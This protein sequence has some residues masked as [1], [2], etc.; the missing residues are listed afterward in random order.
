MYQPKRLPQAQ[1]S[2]LRRTTSFRPKWEGTPPCDCKLMGVPDCKCDD[3]LSSAQE[4][5][6]LRARIAELEQEV[7]R[8][9][10]CLTDI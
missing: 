5:A 2:D 7:Q 4:L 3:E 10:K 1:G 8:L 6:A 9:K